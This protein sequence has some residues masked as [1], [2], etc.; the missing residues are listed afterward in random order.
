MKIVTS[1]AAAALMFVTLSAWAPVAQECPA[2]VT[3][4]SNAGCVKPLTGCVCIGSGSGTAYSYPNCG[5]CQ[6]TFTGQLTC[7]GVSNPFSCS[8][9]LSCGA[10]SSCG[11]YCPC[12]GKPYYPVLFDC[13]NCP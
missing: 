11:V 10:H 12:T 8:V 9:E 13:G 3:Q 2:S 4:D 5:G 6:C 7:S 1:M